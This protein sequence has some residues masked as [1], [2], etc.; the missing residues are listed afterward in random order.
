MVVRELVALLG[1]KSDTA[2]MKKAE[3]GMGNLAAAAKV[4]AA[5]FA[6]AFIVKWAR[7]AVREIAN[8]GDW[9]DKMA[10]RTGFAVS[11][12][13]EFEHAATLSGAS[14][15]A[16]EGALKR[17]QTA[18][19]DAEAGLKTYT[20]EFD[21]LGVD[22]KDQQGNLKDTTTLFAE[23]ADAITALPTDAER[24][25]VAM[26]LMGRTGT[27]LLPMLKEGTEGINAMMQEMR[28]LGG[29]MDD[30]L[31]EAS[32]EFIDNQRRMEVNGGRRTR[33]G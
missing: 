10:K 9:Y 12:L 7:D 1:V 20:R 17:L 6:S 24:T 21:R 19:V 18:Q 4:A 15:T 32:A 25:A 27:Q 11:K 13:Q 2:G 22:I 28:D 30:E 31:V 5:A 8:V 29:V 14:L 26:K 3:S 23:M 16:I 33:T